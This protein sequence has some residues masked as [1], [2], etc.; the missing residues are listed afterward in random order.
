MINNFFAR[1]MPK[2]ENYFSLLADMAEVLCMT[3][4]LTQ[5]CTRLTQQDDVVAFLSQIREQKQEALRLQGK[6]VRELHNSF[7]TPFDREDINH[8]TLNMRDVVDHISSCAKRIFRYNPK[9][10]P[11]EICLMADTL[12]EAIQLLKTLII[13]L[14]EIKKNPQ[15][16]THLC[17]QIERLESKADEVYENYLIELFKNEKDCI[18][19]IKLKEII[20][21]FEHAMDL[22]EEVSKVIRTIVVKYA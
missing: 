15:N 1:F 18:E 20:S 3:T 11:E 22:T 7:V 10:I 12:S 19:L 6:I 17:Q 4:M 9:A 14:S 16:L 5:K 13:K 8:L 21:A 2:E